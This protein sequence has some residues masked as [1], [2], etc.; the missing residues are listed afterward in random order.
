MKIH[1]LLDVEEGEPL[2]L[3][4]IQAG[5]P[6]RCRFEVVYEHTSGP[7]TL[8]RCQGATTDGRRVTFDLIASRDG[9]W[10]LDRLRVTR[11]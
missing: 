7:V 10:R 2:A 3:G 8:W 9:Q 11:R 1:E 5:H 6:T 4:F